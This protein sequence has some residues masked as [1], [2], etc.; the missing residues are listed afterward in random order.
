MKI[1]TCYSPLTYPLFHNAEAIVVVIDVLRATSAM[2]TAIANGAACMIPVATVEEAKAFQG[3]GCLAA[4]ERNG[5]KLDGFDFG[6]SPISYLDE[7]IIN[8]SIAISTTNGTQAIAAASGAKQIVI[9]AFLNANA[10]IQYLKDQERDVVFLCAGWKNKFNLEDTLFA[11][12]I[13]NELLKSNAFSTEC[14]STIAASVL[15]KH[16][17]NDLFGFLDK[18]S[19]RNRLSHLNLEAD[20]KFCFQLNLYDT[21]PVSNG[22]GVLVSHASLEK[23]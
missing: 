1:E 4:A 6:N 21:V 5:E 2:V 10:V 18:S 11:G 8:K 14:D 23:V 16:A 19:H 13:A 20:I 12:H 3:S 9:G 22:D 15:Y 17:A 7:K